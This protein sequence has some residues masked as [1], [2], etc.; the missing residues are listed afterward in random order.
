MTW[1]KLKLFYVT[2]WVFVKLRIANKTDMTFY[3]L[4]IQQTVSCYT[5]IDESM[6]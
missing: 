2:M 1:I 6:F 3:R 4:G 5:S